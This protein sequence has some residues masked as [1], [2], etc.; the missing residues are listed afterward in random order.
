MFSEPV[1]KLILP[2]QINALGMCRDRRGGGSST[3]SRDRM[4][5]TCGSIASCSSVGR[6]EVLPAARPGPDTRDIVAVEVKKEGCLL[7]AVLWNGREEG[8]RLER[9]IEDYFANQW[10]LASA[11]SKCCLS[12]GSV[13]YTYGQRSR[14]L[15]LL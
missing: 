12:P 15:S 4:Y 14:I 10:N 8:S 2:L 3:E 13:E 1:F 7:F 11:S 6:E 5:F 9:S